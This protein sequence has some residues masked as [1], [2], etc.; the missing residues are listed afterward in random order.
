MSDIYKSEILEDPNLVVIV[1]GNE[2]SVFAYIMKNSN[3]EPIILQDGFLCSR[4]TILQSASEIQEYIKNGVSPPLISEFSNDYS[5]VEKIS[6]ESINIAFENNMVKIYINEDL[7]LKM[8]INTGIS[9]SKALSKEGPYGRP[10][11]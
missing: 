10:L 8:D 5:V 7:Y 4:G 11:I 1:E 2:Y 6:N 3:T 9:F